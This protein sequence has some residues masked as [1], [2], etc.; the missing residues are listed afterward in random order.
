M[1]QSDST[2]QTTQQSHIQFQMWDKHLTLL[3]NSWDLEIPSATDSEQEQTEQ[4]GT[5][6]HTTLWNQH[7]FQLNQSWHVPSLLSLEPPGSFLG[8][9]LFPIKKILLRWLQPAID[10]LVQEQNAFNAQL[11]QVCNGIVDVVNNE[12]I[13]KLDAQKEF[14]SQLVQTLNGFVE[15]AGSEIEQAT[16]EIQHVK[17][18]TDELPA[19]IWTFDRRKEALELDQISI[20]QKLEQVLSLI[21]EQKP[22]EAEEIKQQLPASERQHDYEYLLFENLYRGD[23]V[24]IKTKQAK[25]I[26]YFQDCQHVLDIGCGRGEFLELLK[27]HNLSGYG[28]DMNQIMIQCCKKKGFHVEESDIFDHLQSLPDNSLGGIFASQMVEHCPPQQLPQLFQLCFNKLQE[29][30]YIVIETQNPQSLYALSHFYRDMSHDKPV[31]PDALQHL[32]K[33][34]GFQD[35]CIEYSSPFPK[36]GLLQEIA[37]PYE[38]EADK[39]LHAQVATLNRNIRQ[40]NEILYGD[41]DYAI[42]ARKIHLL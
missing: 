8:K 17:Q 14:N 18:H 9:L 2:K 29:H 3:N 24:T 21:R 33:T 34:I 26:Q 11:V 6:F 1:E 32:L 27:E 7:L 20:N 15:L 36:G 4:P 42:I 13:R 40:L 19:M 38:D 12:A 16:T 39:R 35:I 30:K 23:E 28:V 5:H 37:L 22:E 25:Y 31:H 41:L 10:T